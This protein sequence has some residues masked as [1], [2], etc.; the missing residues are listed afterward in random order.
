MLQVLL[1]LMSLVG[2][3]ICAP[4]DIPPEGGLTL[5]PNEQALLEALV[6]EAI[7]QEELARA[8][9]AG[10]FNKT[11]S[12]RLSSPPQKEVHD[13]YGPPPT[14]VSINILIVCVRPR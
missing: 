11:L 12:K 5:G 9:R 10:E 14:D 8:R 7:A 2:I 1:A 4:T 3:A 6:D 13:V